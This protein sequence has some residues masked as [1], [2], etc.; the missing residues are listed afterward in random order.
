MSGITDSLRIAVSGLQLAQDSLA[1][2]SNNVA[3]VN[4]E[5]YS[6]KRIVQE[7]RVLGGRGA[8]V[9]EVEIQRDADRFLERQVRLQEGKVGKSQTVHAYAQDVQGLVFGNP[10]EDATGLASV[11]DELA[12]KLEAAATKP[13]DGA[14]RA[15]VVGAAQ[16]AFNGLAGAAD[17]VQTLRRDADQRIAALVG[18]VNTALKAIDD[19][20]NDIVRSRDDAELLDQRDRLVEE[21]SHKLDVHTYTHDDNRIAIFTEGGQALLEYEPR[22]LRYAPAA[23]MNRDAPMDKIDIFTEDQLDPDTGDPLPGVSGEVMVGGGVRA[24]AADPADNI[25]PTVR[26][27]ELGGLLEVRD[28]MLP[29]LDDQLRE[30]GGMLRHQLNAAHNGA[31]ATNAPISELIGARKGEALWPNNSSDSVS[32]KAYISLYEIADPTSQTT[33]AIDLADVRDHAKN[34][35]GDSTNWHEHFSEA[36][37]HKINDAFGTAPIDA[38]VTTD[39]N[40]T[41]KSTDP[42]YA[43]A[44]ADGDGKISQDD[45]HGHNLEYG[46]SHFLGFNNFTSPAERDPTKLAVRSDIVADPQRIASAKLDVDAGPP[47]SGTLGGVGDARGLGELA[48]A[49]DRRMDTVGRGGLPDATVSAREYLGDV[50]SVQATRAA[51]AERTAENDEVLAE[52]LGF[53][54]AG[55]SGVN[56]DEEMAHLIQ[57]QQAYATSA[58][59]LTVADEMLQDLLNAKR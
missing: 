44:I 45:G 29:E 21:L 25:S 31:N 22:V 40:F 50:T 33:V 12:T 16:D 26:G 35:L 41:L 38:D 55:I 4:T 9:A 57:L 48:A 36:L 15:A 54:K 5:G 20:N 19:L 2:T 3:N 7:A 6:R 17:Q 34:N 8:G 49:L 11:F 24:E 52:E 39:P 32:G 58:R 56:L 59:L 42:E 46:L 37:A 13:E 14:R 1:T 27:G 18:E 23:Q 10:S 43:L 47:P 51:N 28:R 30:F 53:Q